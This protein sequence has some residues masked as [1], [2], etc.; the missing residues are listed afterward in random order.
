[1][2]RSQSL[3]AF[4]MISAI[5]ASALFAHPAESGST[6]GMFLPQVSATPAPT[7]IVVA[8]APTP[9]ATLAT[10]GSPAP[11]IELP[12]T[13]G[14]GINPETIQNNQSEGVSPD[15]S[16]TAEGWN[17]PPMVVPLASHPW[18]HYW[19]NRPVSADN[20]NFALPHYTF[21]SNGGDDEFRV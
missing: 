18:D 15:R 21:G 16:G 13:E 6:L 14:Q 3:F 7:I 1:M 8:G 2:N 17:P 12:F 5:V 19:F 10:S 9:T 20:N 11:T 4:V